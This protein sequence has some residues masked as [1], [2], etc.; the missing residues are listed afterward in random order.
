MQA[1]IFLCN[2]IFCISYSRQSDVLSVSPVAVMCSDEPTVSPV[3]VMCSDGPSVS[4]VAVMCSDGPSVSPV[5][6][7]CSDGPSVS[8]VAVKC[9]NAP[10]RMYMRHYDLVN[11]CCCMS[12]LSLVY[13]KRLASHIGIILNK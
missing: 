13:W 3:A 2:F 6:E 9:S 11:E 1:K 8:S 7:M 10:S 12:D 5:A 4:P